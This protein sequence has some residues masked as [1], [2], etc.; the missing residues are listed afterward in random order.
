MSQAPIRERY[1]DRL[2]RPERTAVELPRLSALAA[3]HDPDTFRCLAPLVSPGWRCL[4]V[5]TG[6]GH[7]ARWLAAKVGPAGAVTAMDR[8]TRMLRGFE[9][10][11]NL[12]P[13][14]ADALTA[15]P[16]TFDLVHCRIM[17]MHTPQ[18]AELLARLA[19]WVRP[20]GRLV[21]GDHVDFAT[22]SSPYPALRQTFA[23]MRRMLN[24]T[25]GTDFHFA[26]D[27]PGRLRELGLT[28][29][30]VDASTPVLRAGTPVNEFWLRTWDQLWPRMELQESVYR[31]AREL[32]KDPDVVDLSLSLVTAWGRK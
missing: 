27:Y 15:E 9:N 4:D 5:G 11:A 14:E 20:G 26:R 24:T 10:P 22:H 29:V 30:G 16:G 12:T 6:P 17:L 21:V 1:G 8:D 25:I 13:L 31:E 3:M 19:S 32:L 7:V 2:F 28:E 18:R 23:A